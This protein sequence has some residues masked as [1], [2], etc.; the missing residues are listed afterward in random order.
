MIPTIVG[1]RNIAETAF[2]GIAWEEE[3]DLRCTS[4]GSHGLQRLEMA[5]IHGENP[6][7]AG[8]ISG[9]DGA[10]AMLREVIA[11]ASGRLQGA[12]V[13]ALAFMPRG[14][15]GRGDLHV[16]ACASCKL[17]QDGFAGGRAADVPGADKKDPHE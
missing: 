17:A 4:S 16:D 3:F 13:G 6:I 10:C 1:I 2:G 11:V 15:A 7:E 8:K 5:A 9:P 14:D 12:R